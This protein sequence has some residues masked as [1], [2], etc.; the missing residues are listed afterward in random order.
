M[1]SL[2]SRS[3]IIEAT[4]GQHAEIE[5][6]ARKIADYHKAA[7][8]IDWIVAAMRSLKFVTPHGRISS[9]RSS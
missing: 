1:E 7:C 8:R 4:A 5:P 2:R 9:A 6:N 3:A